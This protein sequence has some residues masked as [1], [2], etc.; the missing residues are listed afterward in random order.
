MGKATSINVLFNIIKDIKLED[1]YRFILVKESDDNYKINNTFTKTEGIHLYY[2]KDYNN[3]PKPI[4]LI[5]S[6][7]YRDSHGHKYYDD[8]VDDALKYVFSNIVNHINTFCFIII[9]SSPKI[10]YYTKYKFNFITI[11]FSEDIRQNVIIFATFVTRYSRNREPNFVKSIQDYVFLNS[12]NKKIIYS[13]D[14]MSIF[15]N[16][17]DKFYYAQLSE[18]YEETIKKYIPKKAKIDIKD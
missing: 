17:K 14:S 7:G 3:K 9:E 2:L 8:M 15:D 13:F 12:T 6:P 18:L 11:L 5:D 16:E 4:I 10:D 1:N